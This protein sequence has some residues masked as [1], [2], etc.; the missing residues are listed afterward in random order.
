MTTDSRTLS[1]DEAVQLRTEN[2]ESRAQIDLEG[3]V[4]FAKGTDGDFSELSESLAQI[5]IMAHGIGANHAIYYASGFSLQ[6]VGHRNA[7][8]TIKDA[9]ARLLAYGASRMDCE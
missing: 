5:A 9:A 3:A 8:L 4:Q 6:S 1:L 7:L 2:A